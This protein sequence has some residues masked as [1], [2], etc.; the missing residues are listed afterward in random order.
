M[1]ALRGPLFEDKV[2]DFIIELAKV[3]ERKAELPELAAAAAAP[4]GA[5]EP[6]PEKAADPT[7]GD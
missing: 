3:K 7:R 2:V 1:A 6:T 4:P 5:A